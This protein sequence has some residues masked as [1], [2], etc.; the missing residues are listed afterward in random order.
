MYR[1]PAQGDHDLEAIR[2]D[3]AD[4]VDMYI[5]ETEEGLVRVFDAVEGS[6]S[7]LSFDEADGLFG[8]HTNGGGG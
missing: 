7:V 6:S 2:V 8:R 3:L 5:R 1:L 4:V